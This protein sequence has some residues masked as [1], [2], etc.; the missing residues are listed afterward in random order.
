M[1]K[2]PGS[3]ASSFNRDIQGCVLPGPLICAPEKRVDPGEPVRTARSKRVTG[4]RAA[5]LA[6]KSVDF[7]ASLPCVV[8]EST[9][10][11]TVQ[12][13]SANSFELIGIQAEA[14]HGNR[15]LWEERIAPDDRGRL[16]M[17]V[18]QLR[19]VEIVW[20]KHRFID[21]RGLPVW[22]FHGF[23][24]VDSD[25]K[26]CI[27]GC[28]VPLASVATAKALDSNVISQFIHKIGNHFQLINLVIGS[29]RRNGRSFDEIDQLQETV[30]RAVEFT[31][32][33][34][35]YSQTPA[36]FSELDLGEILRSISQSNDPLFSEKKV[37][38]RALIDESLDGVLIQ[39]D[40]FLLDLAL[41]SILQNALDATNRADRVIFEAKRGTLTETSGKVVRI[42]IVDNGC[43]MEK[44]TLARAVDPFFTSRPERDGLGLSMAMRIIQAHGGGLTIT[45]DEG[46]GTR[47]EIVLPLNKSF[48]L[49]K[50]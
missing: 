24:K 42:S 11:L 36:Q 16:S 30:D 15:T 32:A 25:P 49:V 4:P 2:M 21:D 38:F 3:L 28:I 47:V 8:Y 20:E 26:A 13:I 1:A 7:L 17:R 37:L 41:G 46:Q 34:S 29:M 45:S 5:G 39:G 23:R 31:R 50:P 35:Q 27:R 12:I 40:P 19:G 9:A 43:G 6:S 18:V 14:L 10:E 44:G 33:F 48:D 22:V